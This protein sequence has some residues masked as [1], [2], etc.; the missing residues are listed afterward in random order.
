MKKDV[1]VSSI[2]LLAT[3]M[4][5]VLHISQQLE[6]LNPQL[7]ILTDWLNLGLVLFFCISGYLY[8]NRTISPM[9]G[10]DIASV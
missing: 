1:S 10:V 9:G 4:V 8:S 7:H 2:R 5:V 3:T 6:R